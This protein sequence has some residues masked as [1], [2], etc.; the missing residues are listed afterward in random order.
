MA[1]AMMDDATRTRVVE[2][3]LADS[4]ARGEVA[5]IAVAVGSAAGTVLEAAAGDGAPGAPMTTDTVVWIAS[6]TKMVTTIA[7][8]QLVEH[9]RLTMDDPIGGLLPELAEP[10]VLDGFSDAGEAI[11][12]PARTK[13]TLRHLL[14]HTSGHSYNTW[15]ADTLRYMTMH[16]IPS[17][18]RCERRTLHIPL[19]FDPGMG[20][21]YGIGVDWAGQA[22]EAATGQR[23]RDVL[24]ERVFGPLGMVD[25]T[26]TPDASQRCRLSAMYRRQPDGSLA[27]AA[28]EM[29]AQPEFDMG[30]GGLHSTARD[31]LRLCRMILNGGTLD[32]ARVLS[33]ETIAACARDQVAPLGVRPLLSVM[34]RASYTV[35]FFPGMPKGWS[36]SFLINDVDLPGGRS[37]GSLALAGLANTYYWIDPKR[38][39]AAVIATQ[40]LPACDPAVLGV[41]WAIETALYASA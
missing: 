1:P 41:C 31:Y 11:L 38:D 16:G 12:R 14:T 37:A 27:P 17:I 24:A 19:V 34:P 25:T 35:D 9:G 40:S 3:T 6:M 2:R 4:V 36:F 33:P 8:L 20:W 21:E 5:G 29:P 15:N 18:R 39:L 32:G 22:I 7:A 28:F 30:G 26:F 23:L 13:I 10:V